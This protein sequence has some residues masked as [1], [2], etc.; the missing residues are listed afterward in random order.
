MSYDSNKVTTRHLSSLLPKVLGKLT[1]N[2]EERPDVIIE[3][4]KLIVGP[5]LSKMTEAISFI[6]GVLTVKVKNSSLLALLSR[7]E[8]PKLIAALREKFPKV[9]IKTI[10][11][12]IG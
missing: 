11:F 6:D 3:S 7:S 8:K 4:W 9:N 12:R 10:L 2:F 1:K 5:H